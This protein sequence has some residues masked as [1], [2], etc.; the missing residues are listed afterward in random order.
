MS[1][2][3]RLC[4]GGPE[5]DLVYSQAFSP[6]G[7]LL[8]IGRSDGL[9]VIQPL[10]CAG[11]AFNEPEGE[12]YGVAFSPDGTLLGTANAN[13]AASLWR[14]PEG[15][16]VRN[17]SG[18]SNAV[19]SVDF[20]PD[21]A[22]LA[23]A[24]TDDTARLWRVADGAMVRVLDGGGG[25]AARFPPMASC[26]SPLTWARSTCGVSPTGTGC[27]ATP[28][29]K[30]VPSPSRAMANTSRYGRSDGAVVLAYMPLWLSDIAYQEFA[31][32]L[33]WQGGSGRYQLQGC[34][35]LTSAQWQD[36]GPPATHTSVT[37]SCLSPIF[38]R[39]QSLP[40]P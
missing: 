12:V 9:N 24:S 7:S 37:H 40:N 8:A 21:G 32:T 16:L 31:L 26:C 5:N 23:T 25:N 34:S 4:I 18:H 39:V 19:Y 35:N 10:L 38:Y 28:M 22:L 15:T 27:T 1:D 17:F 6:D 13:T 2:G 36:L 3:V 11:L 14:V 30:P 20:S 29:C 33:R